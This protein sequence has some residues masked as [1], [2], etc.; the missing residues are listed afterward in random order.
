MKI[1]TTLVIGFSLALLLSWPWVLGPQP[2]PGASN[3]QIKTYGTRAGIYII[4]LVIGLSAS[5][6]GAIMVLRR[7]RK[8]YAA[9]TKFNMQLLV[10]G[11][12]K[13]LKK[14]QADNENHV[15]N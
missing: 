2:G 4:G 3:Q 14:K 6:I 1:F 13:D 12:Q 7:A 11:T 15:D 5:G 8:D 9:Q 10:E